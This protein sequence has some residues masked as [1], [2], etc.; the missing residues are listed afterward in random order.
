MKLLVVGAKGQ[1]G[2][3]CVSLLQAQYEI[4]GLDLPDFD[5][6]S[7]TA[8]NSEISSLQPDIIVNCA[9]YTRVDDCEKYR[10]AAMKANALGPM[11]L[12][13]AAHQ[14]GSMLVHI[15]TDYV[16]DGTR[17]PPEPYV[18]TDEPHPLSWYGQTKLD[19]EKAVAENTDRFVVLRT[20]WLYGRH[21]GNFPK[22][23][24][25]LA[26]ANP[27][28]ALRVVNDQY[29]SPT[30]SHRLAD[31]IQKTTAYGCHGIYH[32]TAEGYCT[33]YEFARRFLDLMNVDHSLVP[34]RSDEYPTPAKRP[35]NSIL[36]NARL[37]AAGINVMKPWD[38]DLEE[39][40][41]TFRE[42]LLLEARGR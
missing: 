37:K 21:G 38:V 40:V 16:F 14:A 15:S 24:L 18:E 4:T 12:A 19:G 23:M 39:F 35:V 10:D 5:M 36:E 13:R 9:G 11:L 20:A 27:A 25:Q 17:P 7:E 22:K 41:A 1:L 26:L 30:W 28:K 6:T 31:Q 3:D 33:W 42:E 2:R 32:S 8:V 29:G 34:C